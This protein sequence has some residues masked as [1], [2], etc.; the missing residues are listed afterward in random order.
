MT[1]RW[2]SSMYYVRQG[3]W[4]KYRAEGANSDGEESGRRFWNL[5][6][7]LRDGAAILELSPML[8]RAGYSY[9]GPL[10][11]IPENVS[12]DEFRSPNIRD[13]QIDLGPTD[14]VVQATRPPMDDY[15]RKRRVDASGANLE[16]RILN[17][18]AH[19]I[20]ECDRWTVVL[21]DDVALPKEHLG[22]RRVEFSQYNSGF[23]EKINQEHYEGVP[24]NLAIGY[25]LAMPPSEETPHR[26]V[27]SWSSGGAETLWFCH[28]LRERLSDLYEK[29]VRATEPRL[30][31]VRFRGVD[32]TPHPRLIYQFDGDS[33][34]IVVE[35]RRT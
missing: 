34:V 20:E 22:L 31:L 35:A 16:T 3:E 11:Q 30:W 33:D 2:F 8:E 10:L 28:L 19:F 6:H 26:I 7:K 14:I 15:R 29:A 4:P 17:A 5:I 13:F 24:A 12:A 1:K 18:A 23:V 9:H 21:R 32:Y 27:M 25:L